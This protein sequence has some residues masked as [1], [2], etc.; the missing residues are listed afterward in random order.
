M[1]QL[2]I[3]A[4]LCAAAA[5]G[6]MRVERDLRYGERERQVLDVYA[7]TSGTGRAVVIWIH[8]G[9]WKAGDKSQMTRKPQAFV[10]AGY[11]FVAPN[12]RFVPDATAR[13]ILG[14]VAKSI[15]WVHEHAREYGGDPNALFVMGHSSGAN[16]AALVCTDSR[17]LAAE[18]LS[19]AIIM[20]CVPLDGGQYDIP[21]QVIASAPT[22]EARATMYHDLF[23]DTESQRE[24]SPM[25]YVG[26]TKGVPPFLIFHIDHEFT[27]TQSQRFAAKL[28]EAGVPTELYYAPDKTHAK[29]NS[30]IG[31][32]DD[33]PT[34][35]IF[36]FMKRVLERY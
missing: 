23:G 22:V 18:G 30:E 21:A 33:K 8:G 10:E 32:P 13:E 6:D 4:V 3:F 19:L 5:D 2:F 12:R 24:L 11:L 20:G 1:Q 31:L 36:A 28:R 34:A 16:V 14:D 15:R 26:K 27:K 9:G 7:P 35:A 17:Y 25:T 29:L